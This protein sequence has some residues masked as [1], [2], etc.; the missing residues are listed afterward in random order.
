MI[1]VVS[2]GNTSGTF[3]NKGT[4][5]FVSGNGLILTANHVLG[6]QF[7]AV[8]VHRCVLEAEHSA[9]KCGEKEEAELVARDPPNDLALL[10]LK[11]RTET[12]FFRLGNM[13][14]I[15]R[16]DLL[17][18]VGMDDTGWTAGALVN[19]F[20]EMASN[21]MEILMP[22]RGGASGGPVVDER[23]RLVGIVTSSP[24]RSVAVDLVTFAV[25]IERAA[26]GL[27]RNRLNR[28]APRV[29]RRGVHASPPAL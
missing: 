24:P 26:E 18:R 21:R 15:E 14:E 17:W 4:G 29:N 28:Q 7:A 3:T 20:S 22:V 25:P 19:P 10:R 27:L 1:E 5:A 8:Y 12:K 11:R 6:G 2:L 23:G 16:G 9:I 13:N